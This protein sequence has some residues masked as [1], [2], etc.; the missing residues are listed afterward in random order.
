MKDREMKL[1]AFQPNGYGQY[2]FFVMAKSEEE[3]NLAVRR[4][5]EETFIQPAIIFKQPYLLTDCR[6]RHEIT[7]CRERDTFRFNQITEFF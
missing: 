3:A 2:S 1:F 5:I 7:I 6:L 4:Y